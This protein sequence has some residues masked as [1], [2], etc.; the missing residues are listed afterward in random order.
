MKMKNLKVTVIPIPQVVFFPHTSIPI[1]VVDGQL[2][3]T[4]EEIVAKNQLVAVTRA[5][6]DQLHLNDSFEKIC[7]VGKPVIL[8]KLMDG[9]L[10]ILV[11]GN[12]KAKLTQAIQHLPFPI[13]EAEFLEDRVDGTR[14]YLDEKVE[15]LKT[16]LNSWFV[17]NIPDSDERKAF[18]M[19]LLSTQHYIDY[20]ATF[21]IKDLEIKQMLLENDSLYE[22]IQILDS[23]L[24]ESCPFS[25]NETVVRALKDF[26]QLENFDY[27]AH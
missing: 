7:S 27:I 16:I 18:E 5:K 26:E 2:V 6:T 17:E 1:Y 10:K 20:I 9:G 14:D 8:E 21:L 11:K 12:S 3:D 23:L 24:P 19:T 22:R 4:I 13:F 15:R 25:Q